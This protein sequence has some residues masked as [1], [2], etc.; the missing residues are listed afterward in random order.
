[1]GTWSPIYTTYQRSTYW[2]VFDGHQSLCICHFLFFFFCEPGHAG[3]NRTE[4]RRS[5]KESGNSGTR[6]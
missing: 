4:G 1:M 3:P 5:W 6:V 2:T